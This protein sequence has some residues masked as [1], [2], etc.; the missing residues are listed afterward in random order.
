[1]KKNLKEVDELLPHYDFT[2]AERGKFAKR[3]AKGTNLVQ[4]LALTN[5]KTTTLNV[6]LVTSQPNFSSE[7]IHLTLNDTV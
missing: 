7:K 5:R 6:G 1:M 3:Y 2:G 4:N